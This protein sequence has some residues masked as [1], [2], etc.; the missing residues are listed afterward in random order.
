MEIQQKGS[1]TLAAYIHYIKTAA[2]QCAFTMALWQSTFLLKG[3][4]MHPLSH[5]T[6]MK[7]PQTLAEV[8]RLVAHQLTANTNTF[9]HQYDVW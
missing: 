9:Y 3:L 1:K 5:L 6:Y 2:K 4:E 7:D 8:I